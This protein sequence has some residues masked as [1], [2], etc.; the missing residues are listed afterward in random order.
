MT[1]EKQYPFKPL[2]FSRLSPEEQLENSQN[3][4]TTL[5]KRRTVRQFSTDPVSFELIQN[6]IRAAGTAP[7]GANLQP[8][9]FVVVEDGEIKRQIR[10]AAEEEEKEFYASK[11]TPEWREALA[12]LGT[13]W[14]KTH[15]EDAPYLIVVFEQTYRVEETRTA[16][17]ML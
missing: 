10:Q 13:D 12:P 8:W 16:R 3:F 9:T 6:A 17:R 11:I 4:L 15:L 5:Q 2:N 1:E 14:I 7:S